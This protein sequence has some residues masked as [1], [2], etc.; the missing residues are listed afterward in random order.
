MESRGLIRRRKSGN[1]S[2]GAE[3]ELTDDGARTFRASSAPHLRLVRRYFIDA[4][5]PEDLETVGRV[6]KSLRRH[7][8]EVACEENAH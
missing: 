3:V 5:A 6:A 8:K 4:I 7:L 1:D 2:R